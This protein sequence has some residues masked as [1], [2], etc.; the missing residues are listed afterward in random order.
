MLVIGGGQ[1]YCGS[2]CSSRAGVETYLL[3]RYNHLGGLWT[4]GLVLPA[5][6]CSRQGQRRRQVILS[7]REMSRKLRAIG[8]SIQNKSGN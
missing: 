7:G 2:N 6:P 1:Q 3:E 8:M 5:S 4:G